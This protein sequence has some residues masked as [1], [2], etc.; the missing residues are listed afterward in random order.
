MIFLEYIGSR[1]LKDLNLPN[2]KHF[3]TPSTI[4]TRYQRFCDC[5]RKYGS[6]RYSASLPPSLCNEYEKRTFRLCFIE[7][8]FS[9]YQR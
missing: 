1:A 5:F 3:R 8:R 7:L 9:E 4:A 2:S 6:A